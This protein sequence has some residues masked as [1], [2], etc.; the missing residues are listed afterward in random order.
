M[1]Y[2][3]HVEFQKKVEHFGQNVLVLLELEFLWNLY[4]TGIGIG[5]FMEFLWNWNWKSMRIF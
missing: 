4:R 1:E 5:T 3:G 2:F